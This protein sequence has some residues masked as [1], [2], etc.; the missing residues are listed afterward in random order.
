M[1]TPSEGN[2]GQGLAAWVG[3][4]RCWETRLAGGFTWESGG[5]GL[6][7]GA[8]PGM[9]SLLFFLVNHTA[10]LPSACL[11]PDMWEC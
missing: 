4:R 10:F 1:G 2:M 11:G 8:G 9:L 7:Q 5:A 6:R 3:S